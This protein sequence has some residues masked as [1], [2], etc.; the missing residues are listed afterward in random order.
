MPLG[1]DIILTVEGIA[2]NTATDL[3]RIRERTSCL[4]SRRIRSR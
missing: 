3:A 4:E 1:G 2:V